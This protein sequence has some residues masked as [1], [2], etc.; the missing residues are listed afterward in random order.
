MALNWSTGVII[1]F[2][3]FIPSFFA[4][5]I[6]LIQYFK[7]RYAHL[8]YFAGMW[9]LFSIWMLTQ[10]ISD[11]LLSIPLHFF[12]FYVLIIASYIVN[13]SVDTITRDSVDQYKMI[14]TTIISSF[15]IILSLD[16]NNFPAFNPDAAITYETAV[17]SYIYPVGNFWITIMI[18]SVFIASVAIYG[19][20]KILIH[21]P[22]NLKIYSLLNVL[23]TYLWG[24]QPIWIQVT[25]LDQ[26]FPG[27]TPG[28]MALGM[29]IIAITFI[30]EPKLAYILP[31]KTYRILIQKTNNGT[32][33]FQHDWN[34]FETEFSE[35]T[36]SRMMQAINTMFDK[37]INKGNVRK[38]KF[39]EAEITFKV[40]EEV[41]LACILISSDSSITLR[42][43]FNKFANNV[44]KDYDNIEK[45]DNSMDKYENGIVLLEKHF[46][47]IP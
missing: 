24:I 25:D 46:P 27:I 21:S 37:T 2:V 14:F 32:I 20:L 36:F 26:R 22:K 17:S 8:K 34:Q 33:L 16:L 15:L 30:K 42:T 29:L 1:G 18:I 3:G 41:P 23:G 28:S 44:F 12:S 10:A 19:S 13:L 35:K 11:L 43:S 4:F 7:D 40:S 39:D 31:F 5:I 47:F 6:T 9:F 45:N 38:I